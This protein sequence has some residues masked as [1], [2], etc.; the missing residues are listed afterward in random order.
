MFGNLVKTDSSAVLGIA[1]A[2]LAARQNGRR[3]TSGDFFGRAFPRLC[4]SSTVHEF[5]ETQNRATKYSLECFESY[6]INV[7]RASGHSRNT[8]LG[9]DSGSRKGMTAAQTR[10]KVLILRAGAVP[11]GT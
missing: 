8:G 3:A 1:S 5:R 2:I 4:H 9:E 11:D 10:G 6:K 7:Y